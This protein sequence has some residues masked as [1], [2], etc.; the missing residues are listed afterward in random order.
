MT[1][2][3]SLNSDQFEIINLTIRTLGKKYKKFNEFKIFEDDSLYEIV[4]INT[5]EKFVTKTIIG[6]IH[7]RVKSCSCN[8]NGE[9]IKIK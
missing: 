9:E 2:V 8:H 6:K 7:W 3:F 1:E 4:T 5:E